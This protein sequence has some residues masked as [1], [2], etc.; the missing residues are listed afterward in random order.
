MT[1]PL[2]RDV[3]VVFDVAVIGLGP[4]GLTLV[5][6]LAKEGLRVVGIERNEGAHPLPRAIGLDHEAMR[7]FQRIGIADP[8]L[9]FTGAYCDTEYRAADN[10]VLRR[11]VQ[12][13]GPPPL[14]WPPNLTFIQ[15]ELERLLLEHA[16]RL[17]RVSLWFGTEAVHITARDQS[18]ELAVASGASERSNLRATYVVG[19]DGAN[20]WLRQQRGLSLDDLNFDQS[21]LVVDL[22]L[23]EGV[24]LPRVNVQLCDPARPTTYVCTPGTTRRWEF[25]MLPGET[26]ED[27]TRPKRI[28]ELLQ[29][30]ITLD[31]ARIWRTAAYRFHALVASRWRDGNC[32][33]AGDACHQ[34]PPFLAQGLNQGLRDAANLAWKLGAVLRK[35]A[36]GAL[37]DTYEDERRRNVREVIEITK[38]LGSTI[39]ERDPARA[40]E[41]NIAMLADVA[42]GKGVTIRQDLLPPLKHGLIDAATTSKGAGAPV[43]QP[44]IRLGGEDRRLDDI[45]R[46]G[47]RILYSDACEATDAVKRAAMKVNASMAQIRKSDGRGVTER[48]YIERDGVIDRWLAQH[49]AVAVVVRPDGIAYGTAATDSHLV[50]L[51]DSL[52]QRLTE[53]APSR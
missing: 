6:L 52:A 24:D 19:C 47:W 2:Q 8:L 21:W 32:F 45:M 53:R 44:W 22:L 26:A 13:P 34:T 15:P 4:V 42:A 39:G 16:Q 30:W 38:A 29:P 1:G 25:M 50:A 36:G 9:P 35:E 17:P 12:A 33:L 27:M 18:V 28:W 51:L 31:Q 11:I 49:A 10:T 48:W 40:H 7:I 14:A 43:P 23:S 5:H 20:S 37:L 3:D 46:H 41:R